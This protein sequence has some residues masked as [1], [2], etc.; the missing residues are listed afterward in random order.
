MPIDIQFT[1]N[2][3]LLN[4]ESLQKKNKYICPICFEFIHNKS[5]FQ[6]R[7]GHFACKECWEG[8]LK[9]RS[10]CMVCRCEVNSLGDL[11]RCLVIE[12]GFA[13]KECCCIYSH[14]DEILKVDNG[15]VERKLVKDEN[16]GCKEIIMVDELDIHILKCNYKFVSCLYNGCGLVLRLNSLESHQNQCGFKLVTCIYCNRDDIK[17][18]QLDIHH[19]ECPKV[20]I[21]CLQGCST[22]IEREYM[23]D[24]IDND[25]CNTVL[26]CKYNIFGCNTQMKRSELNSH[27]DN[28]NHQVFMGMQIDKLT[29]QV[30][31]SKKTYEELLKKINELC[32]FVNKISGECLKLK[33]LPKE[34]YFFSHGYRNTWTISNYSNAIKTIHNA[35]AL[36]SAQFSILSHAFQIKLYPKCYEHIGKISL[37]LCFN[38]V[39]IQNS[40]KFDY[41]ITLVNVL[42][43]SK[44]IIIKEDK[45]EVL[46]DSNECGFGGVLRSNLVNKENG[47][48]S[49]DDKL[50]IEVYIKLIKIEPALLE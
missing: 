50:S 19:N 15:V 45:K 13:K 26:P 39:D 44:S 22:K 21:N 41:S 35:E 31:Q 38:D 34:M 3:I 30:D 43:K 2:D 23:I 6:C 36:T 20:S 37:Y 40:L 49:D 46:E 5:I 28:E 16:N 47:W 32:L 4:Q 14:T 17:K 27:L 25:C 29:T 9:S 24:H 48:L 1:I 33:Y 11:S 12:Q 10:E 8:F 7:A 42:N 18:F